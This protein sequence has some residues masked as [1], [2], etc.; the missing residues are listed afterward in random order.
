[1]RLA[2]AVMLFIFFS[3]LGTFLGEREKKKLCEFEAFSE[4]FIYIKNQVNYFLTPTKTLYRGF[5]NVVL[6]DR[7]FLAALRSHENDDVYFDAWRSA[8]EKCAKNFSFGEKARGIIISFG[9]AIG[10]SDGEIQTKSFDYYIGEFTAEFEKQK[11]VTEKNI[12]LYRTLGLAAGAFAAII[13]I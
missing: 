4:L 9:D 12:K 3:L 5:E 13:L 1:M 7:G 8:F 6:E 11:A 10:K 2:G